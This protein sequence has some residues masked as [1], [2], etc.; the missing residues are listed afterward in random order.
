DEPA[1]QDEPMPDHPPRARQRRRRQSGH[2]ALPLFPD[3]SAD[4][5]A[6][7]WLAQ[8]ARLSVRLRAASHRDARWQQAAPRAAALRGIIIAHY[9]NT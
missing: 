7:G 1:P 2:D 8:L 9:E 6:T 3:L 5:Q 4:A